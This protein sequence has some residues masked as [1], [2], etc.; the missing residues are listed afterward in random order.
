MGGNRQAR[1]EV[2]QDTAMEW[3]KSTKSECFTGFNVIHTG[4]Y[5]SSHCFASLLLC[6]VF[7]TWCFPGNVT[8]WSGECRNGH[9]R[10]LY[11]NQPAHVCTIQITKLS[12]QS[13]CGLRMR[14]V[15]TTDRQTDRQTEREV[16][17]KWL[18]PPACL[19]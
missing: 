15:S 17:G 12:S 13:P 9:N 11:Q 5:P 10:C 7:D 19:V 14:F 8:T 1:E 4:W 2:Q 6:P 3:G 18:I 16:G